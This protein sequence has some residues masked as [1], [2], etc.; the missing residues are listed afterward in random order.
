MSASVTREARRLWQ[1]TKFIYGERGV[2]WLAGDTVDFVSS[3]VMYPVRS[4]RVGERTFEI[5]GRQLHYV[6]HYYNRAWRNERSV[7]LALAFDYLDRHRGERL[8]EIGNVLSHYRSQADHDVLDKYERSPGVVNVDIVDFTPRKPYDG[9]VSISTLEHVGWDERPREPEKVLRAYRQ[10]R[11]FVAPGGTMLVTC[12]IGQ[13]PHL[14]EYI[15]EGRIDFPERH[16][17]LRVSKDN[18]WREVGLEDVKGARYHEPFRNAN[19]LFVG[20]V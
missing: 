10:M 8:L 7:E 18:D 15:A 12:P 4:R 11:T 13:N 6:S 14:D 19:A 20:M 16:Y 9:V 3:Y 2:R 1:S 17:L 5:G